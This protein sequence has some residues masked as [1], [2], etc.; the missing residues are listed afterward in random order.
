M[1]LKEYSLTDYY[2]SASAAQT[3]RRPAR[4]SLRPQNACGV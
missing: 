3:S 2:D 4:F 1:A